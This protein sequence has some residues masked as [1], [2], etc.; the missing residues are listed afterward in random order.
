M[1]LSWSSPTFLVR[2]RLLDALPTATG[3]VV[4]L[5]APAGFGKSV[6]AGQ[7][8]ARLGW[9]TLWA[10]SLLGDPKDQIARALGL[11]SEA[12]WAPLT[13]ALA[14]EPTLLVLEDLQGDEALSPLL[15]TIPALVLLASREA[16][17]YPEL[18]KLRSEGRLVHLGAPE[19]AFTPEEARALFAGRDGWE[20]AYQMTGGWPL[21]LYLSAYT[22][23]PPDAPALL[24]G[25]RDSLSPPAFR[26]GLLLSVL[27]YLPEEIATEATFELFQKGLVRKT[28]QGFQLH[29]LLK[30]MAQ[31]SLA[32]EVRA[33]VRA[34][35]NRLPPGLRAEALWQAGLH[36]ELLA[37]LEEPR[38]LEIPVE[39]LVAW[40]GLLEKGGPRARLRLG[41]ALLQSGDRSG[42]TLLEPLTD[43]EDFRVA[44]IAL[45]YLA[46]Y[47]AEPMLGKDLERAQA[48]LKR[49]LE[50]LPQVSP[51]LAG[52]FLNDAARIFFEGGQPEEA[53]RLLERALELLPPGSPFRLA[54]LENLSLL[55]FELYGDLLQRVRTLEEIIP[56]LTGVLQSNRPGS[57]RDLG[58]LYLLLGERKRAEAHFEEATH[59]PG[60]PLASLEAEMYLAYLREDPEDLERLVG[61]AGL[62]ES[63]YLVE[64]GRAF[65]ALLQ[66]DPAWVEGL[67]GFYAGLARAEL[68]GDPSALPPYPT[69]R[70]ERLHWHAVRYRVG[71][72]A[73]DLEALLHLTSQAQRVLPGLLRLDELPPDRPEL[74]QSYP[75]QEVLASGWQAAIRLRA[76]EIPP[77]QVRVLGRFSVRGPLGEVV[78]EGRR[79]EVLALLLLGLS[80]SEVAFELWPDLDEE[81]ARNN[82]SVW[83]NRL[84]KSLEPWGVP[85][86]LQNEGLV[87]VESDLDQLETALEAGEAPRVLELYHEPLMPGVYLNALE[88]RRHEL[89]ARVRGL[90]LRQSE[91]HYLKRL[92]E[93]DPLDEEALSRLVELYLLRGEQ[94]RALELQ[95]SWQKQI[96]KELG[97]PRRNLS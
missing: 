92:L 30:R 87:R 26:E 58:R 94:A 47:C 33:V 96:R 59:T 44:L 61:R 81:S 97:R 15:R 60:N 4:W 22:R 20:R 66:R 65:L 71:R 52:R 76:Q 35:Q 39:R 49:G 18:P 27:P 5:Q 67:E 86:Y 10:S 74:A 21:P 28:P 57:L 40:R 6:L 77:L 82:L 36:Q 79:R 31:Q 91:P 13:E 32:Q 46:Y 48:Y 54:P 16:L 84:R 43:A 78:L 53:E 42:F 89:R 64:R 45:G 73:Q 93:L 3:Y 2:E 25:L 19:L 90:F 9:R 50:V 1:A 72:E 51:E 75:L 12:P 55:R 95:R 80:R 85:T 7:L 88:E 68:R 24:R 29:D 14:R 69:G 56:K 34:E 62:W 83:M 41:E 38:T 63:P 17:G 11:P 70:E 23:E 37:Y 8:A